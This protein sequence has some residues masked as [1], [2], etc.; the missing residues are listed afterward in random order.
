MN[1]E[2]AQNSQTDSVSA[3]DIREELSALKDNYAELLRDHAELPGCA[4]ETNKR[5]R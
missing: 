1:T 4:R 5:K 3:E 2:S